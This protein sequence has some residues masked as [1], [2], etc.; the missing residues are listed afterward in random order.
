MEAECALSTI[1][2]ATDPKNAPVLQIGTTVKPG[3][4]I[5]SLL[6][7]SH[8]HERAV[9]IQQLEEWLPVPDFSSGMIY[10]RTKFWTAPDITI[11]LE[12]RFAKT[13]K[14]VGDELG[15]ISLK[16]VITSGSST[17]FAREGHAPPKQLTSV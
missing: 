8:A 2:L 13:S 10:F 5:G 7:E 9:E 3:V 6:S 16:E 12:Y 4:P 1:F 15:C 14:D 17:A 11:D